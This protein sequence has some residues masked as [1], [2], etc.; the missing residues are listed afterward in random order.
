[1]PGQKDTKSVKIDGKPVIFQKRL[2]LG[3]LKE[4]Y[5]KFRKE[6]PDSQISLSKFCT[7]RPAH[8]IL[9]NSGGTH[10]VCVC[11][12]HENMKF[13]ASGEKLGQT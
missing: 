6:N 13:M 3:N 1:M 8:C 4:I 2:V 7:L 5:D 12:I 11:P 9:A 10:T